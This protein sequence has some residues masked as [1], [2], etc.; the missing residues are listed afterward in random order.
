MASRF[1]ADVTEALLASAVATLTE[2]GAEAVDVHRVPGAWEL[3]LAC[4][5]L[6]RAKR[7]HAVLA[8][9]CLVRGE[10]AHFD[11]IAHECA[12]GL[13]AVQLE[14]GV[15]VAFG[16]LTTETERQALERADPKRGAK[17]REVALAALEMAELSARLGRS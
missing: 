5:Q 6:A 10:T 11:V 4:A 1:N 12:R 8:F 9:G 13:G 17:G 14:T 15:P 3:P 2:H 7:H 16:V